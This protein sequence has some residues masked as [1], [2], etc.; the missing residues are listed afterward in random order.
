MNAQ[1][2][3]SYS[4]AY[5]FILACTHQSVTSGPLHLPAPCTS[6]FKLQEAGLRDR[7]TAWCDMHSPECLHNV[8]CHQ[9]RQVL[10]VQRCFG[11]PALGMPAR[12]SHKRIT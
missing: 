7:L 4:P 12:C 1:H 11:G 3:Y 10:A 8:E 6:A 5:P 2:L 9:K